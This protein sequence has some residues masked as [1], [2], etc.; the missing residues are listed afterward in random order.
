MKFEKEK[1]VDA[2][3]KKALGYDTEEIVEEFVV[4]EESGKLKK[5]K[6]KINKKHLPPDIT[7]V[8]TLLEIC[9]EEIQNKYDNMTQEQLLEERDRLLKLLLEENKK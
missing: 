8:K 3:F 5:N 7:A 6:K 2:L 9:G 1:I 4:D